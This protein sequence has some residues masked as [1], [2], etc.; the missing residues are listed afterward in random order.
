MSDPT[1]SA[2]LLGLIQTTETEW[3]QR[4]I[5]LALHVSGWS[6][7]RHRSVG[8]VLVSA[9]GRNQL[10]LGYNGF[11]RGILDLRQRLTGPE[12]LKLMVH[13]EANALDNA[14]FSPMGGTMVTTKT[15]CLPCVLRMANAGIAHLV[16]P[17]PDGEKADELR[18][19]LSYATEAGISIGHYTL[20]EQKDPSE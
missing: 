16:C 3:T 19:A 1:Y 5:A 6:K 7:D 8:A 20:T 2:P 13:A 10:S 18:E 12:R 11:P 14:G 4:F 15:P 17:L 9:H